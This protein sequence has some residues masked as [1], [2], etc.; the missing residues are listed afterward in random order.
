MIVDDLDM[1]ANH[2][3]DW[4]DQRIAHQEHEM[5]RFLHS[6]HR[7]YLNVHPYQQPAYYQ[8]GHG[9]PRIGNVDAVIRGCGFGGGYGHGYDSGYN[10]YGDGHGKGP[11][12]S[13]AKAL[14]GA[15]I[16]SELY[17]ESH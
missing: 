14:L 16:D 17:D 7:G 1:H 10:G 2:V 6:G 3:S 13:K 4:L 9:C 5:Q 11:S 15:L 8:R 12:P